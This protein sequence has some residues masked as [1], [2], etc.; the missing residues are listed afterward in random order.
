MI[1]PAPYGQHDGQALAVLRAEALVIHLV[2]AGLVEQLGRL[3]EVEAVRV[4]CGLAVAGRRL[5]DATVALERD[6]ALTDGVDDQ[7]AVEAVGE[8]L[9]HPLV[10]ERTDL[11]L[12][13]SCCGR[14]GV[15][16]FSSW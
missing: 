12:N 15:T 3:V 13:D 4:G 11:V 7:L 16:Y 8:R 6:D 14:P 1:D 5:A 9:P 2:P 10:G